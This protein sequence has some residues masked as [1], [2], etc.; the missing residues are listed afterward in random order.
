MRTDRDGEYYG[1]YIE[2]GQAPGLFTKFLQK[3]RI[4]SQYTMPDSLDQNG[5]AERRN[6]TLMDMVRSMLSN[7]KL[8]KSLWTEALKTAVYILNRVLTK[9][10]PRTLFELFKG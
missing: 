9:V 8:P 7:S 4:V 1:R 2:D 6:Q 10:V 5:V 3:N